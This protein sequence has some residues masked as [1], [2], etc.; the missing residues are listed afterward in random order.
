[1]FIT[2]TTMRTK[3]LSMYMRERI[4]THRDSEDCG[5]GCKAMSKALGQQSGTS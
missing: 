4:V 1:M 3:G 5:K 2:T